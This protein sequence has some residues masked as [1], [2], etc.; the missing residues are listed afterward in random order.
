MFVC[1]FVG[2]IDLLGLKGNVS[3]FYFGVY[4]V[5]FSILLNDKVTQF[6]SIIPKSCGWIINYK[7][8]DPEI[9]LN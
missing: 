4:L 8:T 7:A 9:P 3:I 1:L 6:Q 5:N 2:E